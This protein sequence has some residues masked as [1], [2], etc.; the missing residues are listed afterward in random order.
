MTNV[1][2]LWRALSASVEYSDNTGE[3]VMAQ[4][5]LGVPGAERGPRQR[6]ALTFAATSDTRT[7]SENQ[8]VGTEVGTPVTAF[9]ADIGRWG[10]CADLLADAR[11]GL[12]ILHN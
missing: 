6:S 8:L 9:D 11:R 10:V 12:S 4:M 1:T 5:G 7:V 2:E 3:V